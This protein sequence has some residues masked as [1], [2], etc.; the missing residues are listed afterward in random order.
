TQTIKLAVIT[1]KHAFDVPEFTRLWRRMGGVDV[2]EQDLENWAADVG[3]VR[4][5][6]DAL[7][8][9]HFYAEPPDE[10][11]QRALQA[12]GET[13]Q[14]VIVMHHALLAFLHWPAWS[15]LVGIADRHFRYYHDQSV[16]VRIADPEHP[17]TKGLAPWAM[18]DET[19]TL[20]EPD[21]KSHVLLTTDHPQSLRALAWTRE[22]GRAR[23]FV[24][25]LGHGP[26][27]YRDPSFQIILRRAIEWTA[28]RL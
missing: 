9:Y 12:L 25:A 18:S 20:A 11:S 26:E 13:E 16:P 7:L 24:T 21:A 5:Q 4:D 27:A 15:A 22:H 19:Y 23:V 2:Y 17:I 1:G 6:Y 3:H 10:P 8:F 28:R 14:G